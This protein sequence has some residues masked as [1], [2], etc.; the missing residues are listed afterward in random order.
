MSLIAYLSGP[1]VELLEGGQLDKLLCT[2]TGDIGEGQTQV[3]QVT[4]RARTQQTG[5]IGV[6]RG[7]GRAKMDG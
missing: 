5:Q 7:G 2:G 3:L 1:Q 4:K 6:L